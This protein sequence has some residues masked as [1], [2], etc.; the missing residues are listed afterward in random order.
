MDAVTVPQPISPFKDF[1]AKSQ[2]LLV[3]G[4]RVDSAS[5]ETFE[6]LDPSTNTVLTH[7]PKGGKED[8]NRAVEV[9]HEK[10]VEKEIFDP[11]VVTAPF[12][13]LN[14]VITIGNDTE[15]GLASSVW[16]KAINK[17]HNKVTK[18]LKT[19]TVDATAP[20]GGYKRSGFGREMGIHALKIIRK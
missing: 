1:L 9:V 15:Y 3:D 10:I 17:A 13:D 5:G 12:E 16:T 7:V 14:T 8:I 19:G 2:K 20:F 6:V 4:K 18:G 11:V